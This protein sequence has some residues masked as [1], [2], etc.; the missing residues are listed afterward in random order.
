MS[1]F[2][3]NSL[4]AALVLG[5]GLAGSA[6]A[7][8]YWTAGDVNP[9]RVANFAFTGSTAQVYT[10]QQ[11]VQIRVDSADLILGR[12][13]GFN[14]RMDLPNS[15]FN[16]LPGAGDSLDDTAIYG[17]AA[18][19]AGWTIRI[20]AGGTSGSNFVVFNVIPPDGG[21]AGIVPGEI[22][23]ID[24]LQL[25]SV[26]ELAT[27]G[28]Q[29][30]ADFRFVDP[31][32][33]QVLEPGR[34]DKRLILLESGNPLN[35]ACLP[36]NGD[37]TKKIDVADTSASGGFLSKTAF[38][39]TGEIGGAAVSGDEATE[40][41]FG[42]YR[43]GVDPAF[44]F[45]Y[46]ATDTFVSTMTGPNAFTPAFTSIYLSTDNCETSAVA[47]VIGTG[48]NANRVTFSYNLAQVG[49]TA[50]GFTVAV[51]GT[52][53]GTSVILD[54]N[55][56]SISTV[57]T[58]GENNLPL[59]GCELLP[60]TYNGS[61]VKV[62]SV[63]EAN[64]TT[65]QSFIRVINPSNTAGKVTVVGWDDNGNF[66][67]PLTFNLPARNSRQ[68]NSQDIEDGNAAKFTGAFGDGVGKWR[69]EITGEFSGMRVASLNR[70]TTDGTVTNLTDADGHGEQRFNELFD[71]Q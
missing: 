32:T 69:L 44:S 30:P 66:R 55:P 37:A 1:S 56:I 29:I 19:P 20:A 2:K 63:N 15:L 46:L 36:E 57:A 58:R 8:T 14:V 43:V 54:N 61:I 26:E 31:V 48:A 60:L 18:L 33:A 25:R 34:S 49:G 9:E 68:F 42:D 23:K 65:A 45:G 53:N 71:N 51:C 16:G 5:M 28:G 50:T 64:T 7:Y 21:T 52:V 59:A 22:I 11:T 41:D 10:M 6:A 12:S 24:G 17:G 62:Y 40:F 70:N 38:S 67:G 39:A 3:K 35:R 27:A 47:G 4:A 13:T